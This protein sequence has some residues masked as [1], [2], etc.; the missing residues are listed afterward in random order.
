MVKGRRAFGEG[1][2]PV[3]ALL[4]DFGN[5]DPYVAQMKGA[6]LRRAPQ[7]RLVDI[8]HDVL[9]FQLEQAGF[10]L[11]VS[12]AHFPRGAIFLAVVDPGVGT[13]RRILCLARDGR[14]FLA[15]DNGLLTALFKEPGQYRIFDL[16]AAGQSINSTSCTFHGRDIFAPLAARLSQGESP[17]TMGKE[18]PLEEV[19]RLSTA[20]P[21]LRE[22]SLALMV[23]HIDRFGNVLLNANND[24][25]FEQVR[26]CGK[27]LLHTSS[28]K[29]SV[30][31]PVQTYG[32]L[33][34]EPDQPELY[35]IIEGSQGYLE[36]AMRQASAAKS[37]ELHVGDRV[38]LVLQDGE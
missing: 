33:R 36:I 37:L 6:I 32:D 1:I 4:T 23:L 28:G 27:C 14:L 17:A 21:S 11:H 8:S 10:Y 25:C 34:L 35:G 24:P 3:I 31:L 16:T 7:V 29:T 22:G 13:E 12:Y 19:V 26:Q 2:K 5:S 30:L 38:T 18:L 15:P 9:P 20:E